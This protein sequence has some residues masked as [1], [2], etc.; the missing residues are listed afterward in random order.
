MM[1][2]TFKI[3]MALIAIVVLLV[4][5]APALLV[6]PPAP[7]VLP[8]EELAEPDSQFVE[9]NGVKV[10]YK[11]SGAGDAAIILLHGF[12]ASVFSWREVIEPLALAGFGAIIAY[13]RP[14]FG[15]TERPTRWQGQNPYS[16]MGQVAL[17]D[18]LMDALEIEQAV[19][20]GNSAGGRVAAAYALEHPQRVRAL[21]MVDAAVSS[22]APPWR[23]AVLYN[24]PPMQLIG[25]LM[26]RK[27]AQTGNDS[28]REAWHA[29]QLVSDGIIAGYRKPLR[30]ENWDVGLWEYTRA[31]RDLDAAA[32]LDELS[33]P[34]L[35]VSG[36]DDRV[37][38]VENSMRLAAELPNAELVIFENCGHLP[39][40][41]CPAAFLEALVPFLQSL[42]SGSP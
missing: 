1:T 3:S 41:E 24:L 13:D 37:I 18:G 36:D 32:R 2:K 42:E 16:L 10:H 25:P 9:I 29:P 33:L 4:M 7:N 15:F 27:I 34:V 12:G 28:I 26:V 5:A 8:V 39:Q 6:V 40:E 14:A 23:Q 38:P 19:L 11:S 20:V 22:P 21:V 35:V 17:L 31:R 30:A